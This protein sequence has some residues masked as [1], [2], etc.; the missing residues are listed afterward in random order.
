MPITSSTSLSK[1][2]CI[3]FI[4]TAKVLLYNK[5]GDSFLFRALL[6]SDYSFVSEDV[7]NI[8]GLKRKNDGLSLSGIRIRI[9]ERGPPMSDEDF[10]RPSECDIILGSD[11]FFTILLNRKIIGSEGQPIAQST[12]FGWV[13]ADQIQKDSNSSC[14]QSHLIR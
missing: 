11:C 1:S 6:G 12:M 2:K 4:P 10:S 8:L 9:F 7:I 13:V 3:S 5:E 14:T